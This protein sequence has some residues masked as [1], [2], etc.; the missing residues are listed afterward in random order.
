VCFSI[1]E[2]PVFGAKKFGGNINDAW[3]DKSGSIEDFPSK[4]PRGS[5]DNKSENSRLVLHVME[6]AAQTTY[7]WNT[8]TQL[9]SPVAHLA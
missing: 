4:I 2:D 7:L 5:N 8:D 1:Q 3:L 9:R 6:L